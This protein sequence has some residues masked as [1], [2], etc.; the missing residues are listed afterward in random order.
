MMWLLIYRTELIYVRE[1]EVRG[2]TGSFVG[3]GHS[4]GEYWCW[5]DMH[6]IISNIVITK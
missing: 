3:D 6:A 2:I 4:G 1:Q 5:K